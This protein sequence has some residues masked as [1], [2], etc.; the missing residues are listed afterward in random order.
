MAAVTYYSDQLD[1]D[2]DDSFYDDDEGDDEEVE[3]RR[4]KQKQA[5]E[6]EEEEE[7]EVEEEEEAVGDVEADADLAGVTYEEGK[8][9]LA[10]TL[11]LDPDI[12]SDLRDAFDGHAD[13]LHDD[14]RNAAYRRAIDIAAKGSK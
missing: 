8:T 2:F 11:N 6:E 4:L 13:Y 10:E 14:S 3:D 9:L 12:S 5:E 1:D 7:E